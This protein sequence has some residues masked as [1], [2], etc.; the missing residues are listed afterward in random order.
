MSEQQEKKVVSRNVAVA[1]GIICILLVVGLGG[2]FAYYVTIMNSRITDKDN[3]ISSL[4]SELSNLNGN[5]SN[6]KL[7][8]DFT[9]VAINQIIK[10]Q[11][12]IAFGSVTGGYVGGEITFAAFYS[13]YLAVTINDSTEN[14]MTVRLL[15]FNL[16][17]TFEYELTIPVNGTSY[18]PVTGCY[19]T[20]PFGGNT[21][22]IWILFKNLDFSEDQATV[23]IVY[24]Y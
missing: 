15:C 19:P 16:G 11:T 14:P 5:F 23:T 7:L 20:G 4:N 13:G 9:V 1:L 22:I 2:A 17:Y 10:N 3:T 8:K 18:F 6:Y 24:Y 21:G 12:V